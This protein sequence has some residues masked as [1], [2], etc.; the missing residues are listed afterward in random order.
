MWNFSLNNKIVQQSCEDLLSFDQIEVLN[1]SYE[2]KR[3]LS[4]NISLEEVLIMNAVN[5]ITVIGN[6]MDRILEC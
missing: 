2:N 6:K 5:R 3:K 4:L 1:T